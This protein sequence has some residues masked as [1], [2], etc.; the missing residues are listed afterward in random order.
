MK[1]QDRVTWDEM[2]ADAAPDELEQAQAEAA[3]YR[4]LSAELLAALKALMKDNLPPDE[5]QHVW[6]KIRMPSDAECSQAAATIK[7]AE[8]QQ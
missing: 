6:N 7:K 3:H 4:S 5:G 8:A 1:E 2:Q